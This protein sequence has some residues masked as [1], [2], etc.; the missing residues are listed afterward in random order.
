MTFEARNIINTEHDDDENIVERYIKRCFVTKRVLN[1][2][3]KVGYMYR[4]ESDEER[5]SGWRIT[6]NTESDEYMDDSNNI[7]Y[8]SLG[9]VLSRDDSIIEFLDHPEGSA[10][11]RDA[12][13]GV[14]S[15]V[16]N[17]G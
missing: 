2:G 8:V 17:G 15:R 13:T 16:A 14:L 7:A 4:E 9:A 3:Y 6:S 1:E 5:D 12:K 10:F 11:I